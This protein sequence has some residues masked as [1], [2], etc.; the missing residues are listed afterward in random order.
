MIAQ[1]FKRQGTIFVNIAQ[2][3]DFLYVAQDNFSDPPSYLAEHYRSI[4]VKRESEMIVLWRTIVGDLNDRNGRKAALGRQHP[5]SHAKS[6]FTRR[7]EVACRRSFE[8][9]ELRMSFERR[10]HVT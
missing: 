7:L 4:V 10:F 9:K 8:R 1:R 6:R 3:S 2:Q 5:N